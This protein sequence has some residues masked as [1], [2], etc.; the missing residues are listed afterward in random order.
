MK[1]Q[2]FVPQFYM[3]NFCLDE[4]LRSYQFDHSEEFPPTHISNICYEDY[5]YSEDKEVE[6]AMSQLEGKWANILR[7]V[8]N[9]QRI[10][11]ITEWEY[12]YLLV[13]LTYTHFR[14]KSSKHESNEFATDTAQLLL[15]LQEFEDNEDEEMR[16][17]AVEAFESEELAVEHPGLFHTQELAGLLGYAKIAD[18]QPILLI[19]NTERGFIFSDHPVILE[20]P[21]F[22]SESDQ[23]VGGLQSQGLQIICPLSRNCCLFLFDGECYWP[24]E[25]KRIIPIDSDMV[26]ELNRLQ[27]VYGLNGV[28]Y[29]EYREPEMRVLHDE[30]KEFRKPLRYEFQQLSPDEHKLDTEN[31][32]V[33]FGR[34]LSDY[35]PQF[36][37][38]EEL[39]VERR[40]VRD[41][42]L[43][44][45]G[46]ELW[47][48]VLEDIQGDIW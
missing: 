32:I 42:E 15:E 47:D 9:N 37:F 18:L 27:L 4:R 46:K 21:K 2:H 10:E 43:V 36:N 44:Q 12:Y 33:R 13:F 31:E 39:E 19:D 17:R 24:K 16:Q 48:D 29:E 8:I 25:G 5:F 45:L 28:Y 26:E 14:T 23:F 40:I 38:L 41:P 35:K 3:R 22:K 1:K 6:E 11:S 20:N 7:E 30:V 34:T